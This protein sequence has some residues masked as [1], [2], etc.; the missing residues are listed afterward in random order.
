MAGDY[1][2]L[3]IE[4]SILVSYRRDPLVVFHDFYLAVHINVTCTNTQV[5]TCGA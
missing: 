5:I 4:L 3:I 2:K 1:R